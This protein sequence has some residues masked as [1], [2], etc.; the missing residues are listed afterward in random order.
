MATKTDTV[1]VQQFT[2]LAALAVARTRKY[3]P[4]SVSEEE[5]YCVSCKQSTPHK[6]FRIKPIRTWVCRLCGTE[7][8]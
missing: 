1:E 4:V 6:R 5:R 8:G 2:L 7:R 3:T